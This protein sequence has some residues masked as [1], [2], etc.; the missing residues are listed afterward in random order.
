MKRF[1]FILI[2][3]AACVGNVAGQNCPKSTEN[4]YKA[5]SFEKWQCFKDTIYYYKAVV[6]SLAYFNHNK[7]LTTISDA[8]IASR[9][10]PSITGRVK[11]TDTAAMLAPYLR[12]NDTAKLHNQIA[13]RVKYTDT[14]A[15]LSPYCLQSEIYSGDYT[16][17]A[18]NF[19]NI[20][21]VSFAGHGT[22]YLRIGDK[23]FVSGCATVDVTDNNFATSFEFTLP[24]GSTLSGGT[25]DISGTVSAAGG[26][27]SGIISAN[28]N[29][30]QFNWDLNTIQSGSYTMCYQ[31]SYTLY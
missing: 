9:L 27:P 1:L 4:T 24:I 15:M 7:Q 12:E 5:Y 31:Y 25:L 28:S 14:A 20:T 18:S 2:M 11:Y 21:S 19:T 8:A 6:N 17:M 26:I 29:H 16:P 13:A 22:R 10:S 30:A 23:V 3:A